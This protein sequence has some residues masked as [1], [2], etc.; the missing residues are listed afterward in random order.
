[1]TTARL[2]HL[3]GN[4]GNGVLDKRLPLPALLPSAPGDSLR[5]FINPA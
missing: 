5:V 1:M 2:A 3:I 4:G